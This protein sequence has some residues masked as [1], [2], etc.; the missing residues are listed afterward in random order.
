LVHRAYSALS[1]EHLRTEAGKTFIAGVEHP[2][3]RIQLLLGGEKMMNKVLRQ[4]LEL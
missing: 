1:N 3:I 4:A 2:A